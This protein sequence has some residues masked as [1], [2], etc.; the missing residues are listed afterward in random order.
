MQSTGIYANKGMQKKYLNMRTMCLRVY[1]K[2]IIR[3]FYSID[4]LDTYLLQD[5]NVFIFAP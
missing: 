1:L 4:A 2:G 3:I 5:I